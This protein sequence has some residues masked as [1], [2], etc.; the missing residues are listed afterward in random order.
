MHIAIMLLTPNTN[1]TAK[2]V[3]VN[4]HKMY[5]RMYIQQCRQVACMCV[6]IQGRCTAKPV[7]V[8]THKMCVYIY[9]QQCT[10][11]K[12]HICV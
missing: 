12:L 10:P 7:G 4:T 3:G 2:P 11:D 1:I 6:M 8:N 5:I 9:I